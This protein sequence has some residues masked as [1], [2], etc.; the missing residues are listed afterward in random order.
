MFRE[1][2]LVEFYKEK[3]CQHNFTMKYYEINKNEHTIYIY[4]NYGLP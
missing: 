4:D 1:H 2:H 3:G